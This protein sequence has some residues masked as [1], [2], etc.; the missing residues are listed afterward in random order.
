MRKLGREK[1]EKN[2]CSD[3]FARIYG[4]KKSGIERRRQKAL[5]VGSAHDFPRKHFVG[6]SHNGQGSVL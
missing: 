1:D 4:A 2:N 5:R 6:R 3:D